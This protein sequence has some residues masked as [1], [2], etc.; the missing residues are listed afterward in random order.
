MKFV[1]G[2]GIEMK[3]VRFKDLML[4][5]IH[6]GIMDAENNITCACCNS[7]FEVGE[8]GETFQVLDTYDIYEKDIKEIMEG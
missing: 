3:F 5:E 8:T 2:T 4:N 1:R 7:L 6:Y